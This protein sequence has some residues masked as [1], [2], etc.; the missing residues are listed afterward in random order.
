MTDEERKA[1]EELRPRIKIGDGCWIWLGSK[2]DGYGQ[3]LLKIA[4]KWKPYRVHRLSWEYHHGPIP[5][6]KCV[7]HTCDVR[8]CVNPTHLFIGTVSDNNRDMTRKGRQRTP[9]GEGNGNAKITKEAAEYIQKNYRR[10]KKGSAV[11]LSNLFGIHRAQVVKVA[12]GE[13]W[14]V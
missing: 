14:N 3:V 4:G 9:K 12:R 2:V 13:Y 10:Y 11:E 8:Q 7:C 5:P 1:W 6:G